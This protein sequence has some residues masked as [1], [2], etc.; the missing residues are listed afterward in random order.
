MNPQHPGPAASFFSAVVVFFSVADR[1]VLPLSF[2]LDVDFGPAHISATCAHW[3][4]ISPSGALYSMVT[5]VIAKRPEADVSRAKLRIF[6]QSCY[7]HS[8]VYQL[9]AS[10]ALIS[11]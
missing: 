10:T 7:C 2:N 5:T 9:I 11:A 8:Q 3:V 4:A 6:N 1:L